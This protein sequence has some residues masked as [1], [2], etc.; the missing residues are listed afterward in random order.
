MSDHSPIAGLD[1]HSSHRPS[2]KQHNSRHH[3]RSLGSCR[4]GS[5]CSLQAPHHSMT[6]HIHSIGP[7]HH[8]S[9]HRSMRRSSSRHHQSSH[10]QYLRGN[11]ACHYSRQSHHRSSSSHSQRLGPPHHSVH[12]PTK[13]Q[14][15]SQ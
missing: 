14:H 3:Q 11:L 8:S 1:H 12:R 6:S 7:Y 5:Q 10:R 4:Q 9:H 2:R 13:S 15:S